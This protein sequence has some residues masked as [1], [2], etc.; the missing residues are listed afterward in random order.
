MH[1]VV[2]KK[3]FT[4]RAVKLKKGQTADLNLETLCMNNF[5]EVV[6][7]FTMQSSFILHLAPLF[8]RQGSAF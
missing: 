5:R 8:D 3:S 2:K 4:S 7:L 6:V 1:K